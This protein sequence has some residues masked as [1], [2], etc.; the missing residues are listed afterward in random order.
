MQKGLHKKP[1]EAAQCAQLVE[2]GSQVY[3]HREMLKPWTGPHVV[4]YVNGKRVDVHLGERR[5]PRHFNIAE[6]YPAPLPPAKK[7]Y[8]STAAAHE[9]F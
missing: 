4:A 8:T 5:G 9:D 1:T 7:F 6:V 3:V 2:T